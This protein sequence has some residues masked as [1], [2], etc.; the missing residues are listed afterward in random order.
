[1]FRLY[2]AL[3]KARKQR[4]LLVPALA[5]SIVAIGPSRRAAAVDA[6]KEFIS[7]PS[8]RE[9]HDEI[10]PTDERSCASMGQMTVTYQSENSGPPQVGLRITDPRG[11]KIG[12]DPRTPKVWQDLPLAT[13]FV[14]CDENDNLTGFE[15]CSAH[16]EIC[17]PLS[18]NYTLEVLPT[19]NVAYAISVSGTSQ[20]TRDP[21]GIHATG[22][23]AQYRSQ[24]RQQAPDILTLNYSREAGTQIKLV[25]NETQVAT[26]N[27]QAEQS[28]H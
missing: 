17:G 8:A 20:S 19:Q 25:S 18:G 23:R 24:I 10:D 14:E 1:M 9:I 16:I 26:S 2:F 28:Q 13:G 7:R 22:S 11:R 15:R 21:V 5:I 12:Y 3:G 6:G 4:R 27:H